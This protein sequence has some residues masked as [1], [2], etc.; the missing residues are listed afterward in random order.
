MKPY[1]SVILNVDGGSRGNPGPAGAGVVVRD[2]ATGS[3]LIH[4]G[5][6]LGRA[7]N[8]VAEY[9]GLIAGLAKARDLGAR[10]VKVYSDSQLLVYQMIGRYK[11]KHPGLAELYFEAKGLEAD[12]D[13]CDYQHIP[14]E[15]NSLAD[16]LANQAMNHRKGFERSFIENGDMSPAQ[17]VAAAPAATARPKLDLPEVVCLQSDIVWEDKS[18]NFAH[19]SGM[20]SGAAIAPG[21]LVVLPEMFA[22]GF[23]MNL[24]AVAQTDRREDEQFLAQAAK[25]FRSTFLGGVVT[26]GPDGKGRNQAV[27]FA[28][29]GQEMARFTK[30]HP[31]TFAGEQ[32]HFTAGEGLA[33]FEWNGAK[34]SPF[35]CY[36]LR[37]P[38]AFRQAARQGAEMMVVLANWPEARAAHWQ[39]MLPARAVENQAFVVGVNRVGKSSKHSYAGSS[40]ILDFNGAV[41]ADAGAE[42]GTIRAGIDIAALREYRQ[43]FPVIIDIRS[44]LLR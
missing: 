40:V 37:F 23:S 28:P 31:F 4:L 22:T 38:E 27:A 21:S 9:R 5:V 33:F 13:K 41:L 14:R 16:E 30:L 39:A 29:D 43:T 17:A 6:F 19:V 18:A 44:D 20:L 32:E 36:D 24:P 7:T 10:S 42:E 12:F 11:V 3:V 34:V 2:A 1:P 8:N 35:V 25:R 26:R 15:Q